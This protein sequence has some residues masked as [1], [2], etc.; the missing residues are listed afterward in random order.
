MIF[1]IS[2]CSKTDEHEVPFYNSPD[3]TPLWLS[4]QSFTAD[5]LHRISSFSFI[6]QE[7]QTITN[8]D[9]KNK[10][11]VANFFFTICP[12]ICPRMTSNLQ[13]VAEAFKNDENIPLYKLSTKYLT[14][15]LKNGIQLDECVRRNLIS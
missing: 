14:H 5:T 3:F 11:Y 12:S 4:N 13:K 15:N 7:N 10:I 8:A 1:I 6:D 9:F 2:A